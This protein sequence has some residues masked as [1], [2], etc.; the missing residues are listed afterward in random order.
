MIGPRTIVDTPEK[1]HKSDA[2]LPSQKREI[3]LVRSEQLSQEL[4]VF[5]DK[6]H[7]LVTGFG[8]ILELTWP[9]TVWPPRY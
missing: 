2:S 5:D 3:P 7:A 8:D 4:G 1:P 6:V 9:V